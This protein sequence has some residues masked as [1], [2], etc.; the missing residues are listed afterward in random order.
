M[1]NKM[2][3]NILSLKKWKMTDEGTGEIREGCSVF[4]GQDTE[5][6]SG[7]T[8]GW[9]VVKFSAP[10]SV[11]ERAKLNKMVFPSECVVCVAL[12]MGAG[13]KGTMQVLDI[14]VEG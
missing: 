2:L 1:M 6:Q 8:L 4:L 11:W 5:D 3:L 14:E 13:G 12:K 10:L 7:N 9:D